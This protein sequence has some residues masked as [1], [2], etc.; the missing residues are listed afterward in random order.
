[1]PVL[2]THG[3]GEAFVV[4]RQ[5]QQGYA[6]KSINVRMATIRTY[7]DLANQAGFITAEEM[8][9]I[10]G[11]RN[12]NRKAGRNI[13]E[14]RT[15]QRRG[16]KKG[17]T[18]LLSA[19]HVGLIK[20][21]LREKSHEN[22]AI[23][24]DYLIFCLLVDHG[25]RCGE[26][27][28]LE[29][30]HLDLLVGRLVFYRRKV[31]K[32]Q[33]H[34]L[35]PDTLEAARLYLQMNKPGTKLF[36]GYPYQERKRREDGLTTRAINAIVAKLGKMI[37]IG[38]NENEPCLSPMIFATTGQQKPPVRVQMLNR[39]SKLEDGIAHTCRSI[40]LKRAK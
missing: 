36:Q 35:T 21:T 15:T 40:T 9:K 28:G 27:A 37:G 12:I 24:R 30:L 8:A 6:I 10:R 32:V 29:T 39:F 20:R 13:D 34:Q 5:L 16:K 22:A 31:D 3:F 26:I 19:A 18:V 23:A 38:V 17:Q 1:M 2:V 11:I 4:H 7:C 25:L 14:K 33:I